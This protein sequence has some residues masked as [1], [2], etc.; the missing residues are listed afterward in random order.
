MVPEL[1]QLYSAFTQGKNADL[2]EAEPFSQY[3][4]Q[5]EAAAQSAETAVVEQYWLDQ[6][7]DSVP[8]VDFPTDAPRPPLRTF[9]SARE[10]WELDGNW[11]A[12]LKQLGKAN[13][14]S[15]M[16]T[17]LSG[18]EVFL[19]RLTGQSLNIFCREL[20]KTPLKP[21]EGYLY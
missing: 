4:L 20:L 3:A 9:N 18:F 10:D 14:C 5:L 17:L 7:A 11:S 8:V 19:Y 12:N 21:L 6:F 15:F 1:G 13:G 16:T 2:P